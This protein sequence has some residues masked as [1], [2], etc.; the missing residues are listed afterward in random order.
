MNI[1]S[2]GA[3]HAALIAIGTT[4]GIAWAAGFRAYMVEL[5]G[6]ASTFGWWGT[7]GAL[8]LP[9]AVVG[10]LLGWAE[11]LRRDGGRRGWRWLALAPLV[12]AIAPLL[13]PGAIITL[14]TEGLGGGAI[15]VALIAVGGGYGLSRRGPCWARLLCGLASAALLAALAMAGP[16]IAGPR[17]AL[18]EPRGAWVALLLTSFLVVLA[19]ASSIPHRPSLQPQNQCRDEAGSVTV[20]GLDGRQRRLRTS[21]QHLPSTSPPDP[22]QYQTPVQYQQNP[23]Q[24]QASQHS[25]QGQQDQ[26]YP[27]APQQQYQQTPMATPA[28]GYQQPKSRLVAGL[29]GIFLGGLGIHRFYLGYTTMGIVQILLTVLVSCA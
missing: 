15:A 12:V 23:G 8:V 13:M 5:A 16:G 14:L 24:P 26:A 1:H 18:T 19:L 11:A 10:G 9:G 4:C 29:L 20:T 3:R 17:L 22:P 6:P 28:Y 27:P 25:Y 2:P 7:F 21:R